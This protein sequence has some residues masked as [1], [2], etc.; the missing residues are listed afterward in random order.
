MTPIPTP[1]GLRKAG[2][3]KNEGHNL[4][5]ITGNDDDDDTARSSGLSQNNPGN[6]GVEQTEVNRDAA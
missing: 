4:V 6:D 2:V 1:L 5:V 3:Q